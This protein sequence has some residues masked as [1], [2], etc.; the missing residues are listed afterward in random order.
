MIVKRII[1]ILQQVFRRHA[2]LCD[3]NHINS[4]ITTRSAYKLDLLHAFHALGVVV[5][6]R[7]RVAH[8]LA[9]PEVLYAGP[10]RLVILLVRTCLRD[11]VLAE[12]D[13][14]YPGDDFGQYAFVLSAYVVLG[15][16]ELGLD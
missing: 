11:P 14:V 7:R 5:K 13:V 8:A 1:D 2:V 4:A 9:D 3:H 10:V 16:L 15:T 12:Q 6:G